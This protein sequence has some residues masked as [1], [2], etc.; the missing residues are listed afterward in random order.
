MLYVECTQEKHIHL[1]GFHYH[2]GPEVFSL[3]HRQQST[4]V[5]PE[6]RF[7][8]VS[9]TRKRA[10]FSTGTAAKRTESR[11]QQTQRTKQHLQQNCTEDTQHKHTL[12][13][14]LSHQI[15][16]DSR[17][18]VALAVGS[19]GPSFRSLPRYYDV[20]ANIFSN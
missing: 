16:V 5:R 6:C 19:P 9:L 7:C 10:R 14:S 8:P 13:L 3:G 11:S 17:G 1:Y 20:A 18:M 15:M 4:V 2:G 12:S